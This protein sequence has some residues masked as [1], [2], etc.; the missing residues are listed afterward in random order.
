MNKNRQPNFMVVDK[1]M[2]FILSQM[3]KYLYV[4]PFADTSISEVEDCFKRFL[5]RDDIDII[6]INQNV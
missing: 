4:L 2:Y 3:Q 1:S 6:L 5:K